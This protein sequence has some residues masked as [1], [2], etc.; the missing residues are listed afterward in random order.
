MRVGVVRRLEAQS[1]SVAIHLLKEVLHR[2]VRLHSSLV[3]SVDAACQTRSR[4]ATGVG[5]SDHCTR[6]VAGD[7]LCTWSLALCTCL[8]IL[9]ASCNFKEVLAKV[10]GQGYRR[11]VT[12]RQHETVKQVPH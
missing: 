12:T 2:L 7:V 4:C 10:L 11:I 8:A 3:F 9:V 5:T 1:P 6:R